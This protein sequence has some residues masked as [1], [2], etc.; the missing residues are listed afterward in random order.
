MRFYLQH[1]VILFS[2]SLLKHTESC[3][4]DYEKLQEALHQV[5]DLAMRINCTERESLELE[6]IENLIDGLANLV[7]ADRQFL[8][9]DLVS[10]ACGQGLSRK[11]RALF[12]FNDL[13]I[14]TSVKRRSST[15]K[16][17]LS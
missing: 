13:L 17:P 14:I 12:L 4:P 9:Y 2:Q 3:H 8:R 10:M 7:S 15:V 1:S 6:Q 11:E 16:K 5:H